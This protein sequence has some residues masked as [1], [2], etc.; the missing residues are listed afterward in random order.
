LLAQR[1][2]AGMTVPL[3]SPDALAQ[4][5]DRM[6]A[7]PSPDPQDL[8]DLVVDHRIGAVADAYLALFDR[9]RLSGRSTIS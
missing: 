8:A 2:G 6:L 1:E 5:I 9:L 7:Q 4:A 3:R